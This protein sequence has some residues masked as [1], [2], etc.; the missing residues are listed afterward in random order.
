MSVRVVFKG[1]S[2]KVQITRAMTQ[3]YSDMARG[4]TDGA[5]D[6]SKEI[7]KQCRA[8]IKRAGRFSARWTDGL[9]ADVEPK[10]G[11]LINAKITLTHD[12]PYFSIHETGGVIRGKPLLWI[13]LSFTGI[14]IRARDF[15]RAF[16][17]L[18]RVNRKVGAPLLLSIK[19]KKPKY[20]GIAQVTLRKR[21]HIAEICQKVM[22]QFDK[23]YSA[24]LRKT[25]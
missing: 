18:F 16:G 14:K 13:P 7:L 23:F 2:V 15:A 3:N 12:I 6:A 11:A 9:H 25:K 19:D 20:F 4:I 5:R 17:G 1:Q 10:S 8:D 21:F 24:R 22:N